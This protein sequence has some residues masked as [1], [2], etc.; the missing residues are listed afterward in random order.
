MDVAD[1]VEVAVHQGGVRLGLV[2]G[3]VHIEHGAHRGAADF[4]HDAGGF[5]Q[6]L[7]HIALVDRQRLHQH[8]DPAAFGVRR[9][10][11]QP[12]HEM[13]GGFRAGKA[14]GGAPLLGEPK[15]ITPP[16]PRSAA[17]IDQFADMVPAS[18]A[19]TRVGRGNVQALGTHHQPVQ[20]HEGQSLGGHHVAVLAAL[21]GGDI[22]RFFRQRKRGEFD[23]GVAGL[24]DGRA[25]LG[26]R[27]FLESLVA[28]GLAEAMGHK[29]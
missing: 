21:I 16:G 24:P 4:A 6:R 27:P 28:H 13:A 15:T 9:D 2:D 12:F 5:L 8:G 3:V 18:L 10:A 22:G 20:P 1:G 25:R 23:P 19:Q 26:K 29:L 11:G 7:D 14:A 17:E